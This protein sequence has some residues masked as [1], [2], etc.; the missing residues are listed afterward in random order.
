MTNYTAKSR[1]AAAKVVLKVND[2]SDEVHW[3]TRNTA[4]IMALGIDVVFTDS[5]L[6]QAQRGEKELADVLL[7]LIKHDWA[8]VN[9]ELLPAMQALKDAVNGDAEYLGRCLDWSYLNR[10]FSGAIP[11][12]NYQ[13]S[14][15]FAN[16]IFTFV[17]RNDE[18]NTSYHY[19]IGNHEVNNDLGI[20]CRTTDEEFALNV[21]DKEDLNVYLIIAAASVGLL[22]NGNE[23]TSESNQ[24]IYD[25]IVEACPFLTTKTQ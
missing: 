14:K 8:V 22:V 9:T 12:L 18:T 23:A 11:W 24:V 15:A 21:S 3:A 10:L 17:D 2:Y 19:R 20:Y 7:G 13:F 16:T 25:G 4:I 5:E 6:L 1:E